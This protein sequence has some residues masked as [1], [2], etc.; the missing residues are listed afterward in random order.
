MV[1]PTNKGPVDLV[2]MLPP[3]QDLAKMPKVGRLSAPREPCPHEPAG[4]RYTKTLP[5]SA[6][7]DN[8][9]VKPTHI[10]MEVADKNTLG[11][12][13]D[14]HTRMTKVQ[15]TVLEDFLAAKS[16]TQLT[17]PKCVHHQTLKCRLCAAMA[18]DSSISDQESY[19]ELFE[20]MSL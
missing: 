12:R 4:R 6:Q 19:Y 13:Q 15:H 11:I 16:T 2:N 7:P 18:S 10:Y 1:D 3:V 14:Q 5:D 20:N 8:N 17:P 9:T